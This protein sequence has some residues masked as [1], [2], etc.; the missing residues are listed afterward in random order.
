[1]G[2]GR[3]RACGRRDG[4]RRTTARGFLSFLLSFYLRARGGGQGGHDGGDQ[5][6]A[7]HGWCGWGVW[8]EEGCRKA[9]AGD[10]PV[11]KRGGKVEVRVSEN[12]DGPR[13]G[14]GTV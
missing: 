6:G 9:R 7:A 10:G 13:G 1:V 12:L 5:D 3:V 11:W 8:V 4:W 2:V 14:C